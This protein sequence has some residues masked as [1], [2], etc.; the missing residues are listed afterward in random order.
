MTGCFFYFQK[1]QQ[2]FCLRFPWLI[3]DD[4]IDAL[5]RINP[6]RVRCQQQ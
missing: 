2:Q 5:G 1:Q 6:L 3:S 4:F